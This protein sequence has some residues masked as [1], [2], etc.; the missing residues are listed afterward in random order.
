MDYAKFL[1]GIFAIC[2]CQPAHAQHYVNR[3]EHQPSYTVE[4]RDVRI[5]SQYENDS[6]Y[7]EVDERDILEVEGYDKYIVR[8][9]RYH[10]YNK[11]SAQPVQY[12]EVLH[13]SDFPM[14]IRPY[15]GLNAGITNWKFGDDLKDEDLDDNAF[16][17]SGALGLRLGN[18][19]GFE[20]FYEKSGQSSKNF[21]GWITDYNRAEIDVNID[22]A[23]YGLDLMGYIPIN[24]QLEFIITGGIA[25]YDFE[26]DAK[27][28]VYN[29]TMSNSVSAKE[30]Y[31]ED[32]LGYRFGVGMLYNVTDHW[33]VIGTARFIK[34]QD[35]DVLKNMLELSAGVRYTF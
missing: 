24:N 27:I 14:E 19:F 18:H 11:T 13:E 10:Y 32:T 28:T 2:A 12:I 22:Y 35:D 29:S 9:P 20:A 5:P 4:R 6:I 8:R 23:A 15:V 16:A 31:K 25:Q 34:M 7:R 30:K 3:V 33:G 1:A 21:K 26:G 17:F